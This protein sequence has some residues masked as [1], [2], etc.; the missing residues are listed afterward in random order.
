MKRFFFMLTVIFSLSSVL[1]Y[2]QR[3]NSPFA[4]ITLNQRKK[5]LIRKTTLY[6]VAYFPEL[7]M[8]TYIIIQY[9]S[10]STRHCPLSPSPSSTNRPVKPSIRKH[11][12]LQ[13]ISASTQMKNH[14]ATI[15]SKQNPMEYS[16]MATSHYR[17]TQHT[18]YQSKVY[19]IHE[20]A[21]SIYELDNT[22]IIR[23]FR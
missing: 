8:P 19:E 9:A 18:I 3:E 22:C 15:L 14:A 6:P 23:L 21:I 2:A 17:S 1:T 7:P 12:M 20:K 13:Q 4:E 5:Q 16:C 10:T 11:A